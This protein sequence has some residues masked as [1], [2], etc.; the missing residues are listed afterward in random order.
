MRRSSAVS[1]PRAKFRFSL[2]TFSSASWMISSR[3]AGTS[4]SV[5]EIVVPDFVAKRK[6]SALHSS[7]SWI[8]RSEPY[9]RWQ[10]ET[11]LPM[12]SCSIA[13]E[14]KSGR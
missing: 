14:V 6:P 12:S 4:M 8:V 9:S 3:L 11:M 5:M 1:R 7:S 10:S 13:F 2:V